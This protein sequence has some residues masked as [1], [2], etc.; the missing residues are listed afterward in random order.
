LCARLPIKGGEYYASARRFEAC[1]AR[2][3]MFDTASSLLRVASAITFEALL[4][5]SC[6]AEFLGLVRNSLRLTSQELALTLCELLRFFG[7]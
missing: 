4:A 1:S 6:A 7:A 3:A 5:K 2:E